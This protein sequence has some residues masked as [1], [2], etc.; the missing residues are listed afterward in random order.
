MDEWLGIRFPTQAP[1]Y[2]QSTL[3][4][5]TL[6]SIFANWAKLKIEKAQQTR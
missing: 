5:L 1:A 2:R 6:L 3:V 4:V